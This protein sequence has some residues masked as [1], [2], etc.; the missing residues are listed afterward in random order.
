MPAMESH[1]ASRKAS[2]SIVGKG[3]T[4]HSIFLMAKFPLNWIADMSTV[5]Y[6]ASNLEDDI[7][8]SESHFLMWTIVK[9]HKPVSVSCRSRTT[10]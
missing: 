6:I 3:K 7:R 5:P 1:L 8:L 10:C 2:L 4:R 9:P